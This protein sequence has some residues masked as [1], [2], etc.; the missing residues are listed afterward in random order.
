MLHLILGK[1]KKRMQNKLDVVFLEIYPRLAGSFYDQKIQ[2][3]SPD[4]IF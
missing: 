2:K 1:K 4:L 3:I